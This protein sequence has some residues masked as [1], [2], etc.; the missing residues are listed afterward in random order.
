MIF[1]MTAVTNLGTH[2][3]S[4]SNMY[5]YIS[6]LTYFFF[7]IVHLVIT[8]MPMQLPLTHFEYLHLQKY[9]YLYHLINCVKWAVKYSVTFLCFLNKPPF[10]NVNKSFKNFLFFPEL[11]FKDFYLFGFQHSELWSSELGLASFVR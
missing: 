8:I 4:H 9:V 3:S 10:L 11:N 5:V 6:L 7:D 1:Q 2:N